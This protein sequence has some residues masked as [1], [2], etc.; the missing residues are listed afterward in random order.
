[1]TV[2]RIL[3][4][5]GWDVFTVGST[6]SLQQV[7]D[8]LAANKVGVLVV[9]DANGGLAGIVSERDVMRVLSGNA[10]AALGKT[11]ADVMTRNVET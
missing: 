8:L 5:K 7:I 9:L 10:A 11:A 4:Q 2:L 1:M 6:S 3:N